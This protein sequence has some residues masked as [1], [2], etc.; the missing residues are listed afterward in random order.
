MMRLKTSTVPSLLEQ[1]MMPMI[2]LMLMQGYS[3]RCQNPSICPSVC[4]QNMDGTIVYDMKCQGLGNLDQVPP[5][6]NDTR[7]I[8]VLTIGPEGTSIAK[9]QKGAF[10]GLRVVQ[11]VLE[12]LSIRDL[13]SNAFGGLTMYLEVLYLNDNLISQLPDGLFSGLAKLTT[14]QLHSNRLSSLWSV[15]SSVNNLPSLLLSSGDGNQTSALAPLVSLNRLTLNDNQLSNISSEVFAFLGNLE[16][17]NLDSNRIETLPTGVFASLT[18]LKTLNVTSNEITFLPD[19][20]FA[21]CRAIETIDFSANRISAISPNTFTN[22]TKLET[23][24]LND[25]E[26]TELQNDYF[27]GLV[28]IKTVRL[29]NNTISQVYSNCFSGMPL[30][31]ELRLQNN[32]IRLLPIGLFDPVGSLTLLNLSSNLVS[33]VEK[34]PFSS[35]SNLIHL[36]LSNNALEEIPADWFPYT[37]SLKILRLDHNQISSINS[38][39][40]DQWST[41]VEVNL[42]SNRLSEIQLRGLFSKCSNLQSLRLDENPLERVTPETFGGLMSLTRLYLNNSCIRDIS[43]DWRSGSLPLLQELYLQNNFIERISATALVGLTQLQTLDVGFNDISVVEDGAFAESSLLQFLNFTQNQLNS[44]QAAS[45]SSNALSQTTVD[46]SWNQIEGFEN[47]PSFHRIYLAGNPFVCNCSLFNNL[48]DLSSFADSDATTCSLID[49]KTAQSKSGDQLLVCYI[50]NQTVCS[51]RTVL[52][53]P[54]ELCQS[55]I[56]VD[57]ETSSKNKQIRLTEVGRCP[58][59]ASTGNDTLNITQPGPVLVYISAIAF[60]TTMNIT[61]AVAD[62]SNVVGFVVTWKNQNSGN[63]SSYIVRNASATSLVVRDIQSKVNYMVC[64]QIVQL[65][66]AINDSSS[67]GDRKCEDMEFDG[68]RNDCGPK[69]EENSLYPLILYIIIPV[70]VVV[71]IIIIVVIVL[72]VRQKKVANAKK[73]SAANERTS[74]DEVISPTISKG[75]SMG[76]AE[77]S[78]VSV[79]IFNY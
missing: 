25:N 42:R 75:T 22:L 72:V 41:L 48:T 56:T 47:F 3:V 29:D 43:F 19:H 46:L 12:K 26:L 61:W 6:C 70:A 11:L 9:I 44:S 49:S 38:S 21:S 69:Q 53:L 24:Y 45:L 20:L 15:P 37:R 78:T 64:V 35:Q 51:N 67:L 62:T 16:T 59:M 34:M 28:S 8:K 65:L 76:L 10:S 30:L 71:V 23:L 17:L 63:V 31:T 36:D 58:S 18:N 7:E 33:R 14:L 39:S 4:G 54:N 1:L 5:T 52:D 74:T 57:T 77:Q 68:C 73:T 66:L 79:N 40:F 50:F 27:L 55:K 60:Q 2:L 32:F 13:D